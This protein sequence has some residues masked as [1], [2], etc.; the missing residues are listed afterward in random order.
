VEARETSVSFR[1]PQKCIQRSILV[2]AKD[3]LKF[4][5]FILHNHHSIPF[6]SGCKQNVSEYDQVNWNE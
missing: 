6:N 5:D 3:K 1:K 4:K 2:R